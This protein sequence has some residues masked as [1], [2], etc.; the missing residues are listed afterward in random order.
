M[1]ILDTTANSSSLS[2][3]KFLHKGP[4]SALISGEWRPR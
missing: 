2:F 3:K 1:I 4:V